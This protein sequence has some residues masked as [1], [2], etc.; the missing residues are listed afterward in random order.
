MG[1]RVPA[2]IFITLA[3]LAA[4]SKKPPA[5][6]RGENQDVL[7]HV[8]L[9]ADP[10]SVKE[11][12]GDDLG[13]HYIVA[14]VKLESKYGKEI[15]VDR[16]D[17]VLRTD[18]D[19]EKTKPFAPSQIAGRGALV[20]RQTGGGGGGMMGEQGGPIIGGMPGT[21]GGPMRLPG[22]S[23]TIGGGGGGEAGGSE[24]RVDSGNREKD[25]PLLKV[26]QEKVLPEKKTDGT[27]S[28]LLYF[29]M[30]KQKVK[31]LELTYGGR[32]NRVTMRFK[33]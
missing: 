19:G 7:L 31:D 22:N 12:L 6:S 1:I 16:D 24:A 15:A 13:G 25:N 26:L 18:K 10:A 21:M 20:V 3:T 29:A 8:T 28:G 23:G 9:Y 32:E 2:L 33:Q 30:E 27:V 11:L 4:A 14:A 17:F 5:V